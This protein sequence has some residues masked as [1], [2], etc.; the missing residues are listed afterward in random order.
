MAAIR[1][2]YATA[3]VLQ[4]LDMGLRYGLDIA[5]A[6]GLRRGTVYPILRRLADEG[7]VAASWEP[8]RIGRDEGRPT[9]RYYR[10]LASSPSLVEQAWERFPYP[11]PG[12]PDWRPG[13]TT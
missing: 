7:F 6:T 2:T 8:V 10:L 3:R 13:R 11:L 9:R 5:D 4:A 12:R 1:M